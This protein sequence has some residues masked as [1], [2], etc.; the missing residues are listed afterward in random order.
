MRAINDR[1]SSPPSWRAAS[2]IWSRPTASRHLER[3][4]RAFTV[5][6]GPRF[7]IYFVPAANTALYRF[8]AAVLGYDCYTGEP[9]ARPRDGGLTEAEW[10][11]LT[12]EPR[13]Y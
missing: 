8:G 6:D 3:A 12:A 4:K 7:A 11:G 10:A 13:T 5:A 2:S 9:A 1:A